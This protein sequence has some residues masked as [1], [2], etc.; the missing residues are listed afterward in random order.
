MVRN[1]SK[2][3]KV[4]PAVK[5]KLSE[6]KRDVY[7][8]ARVTNTKQL[9]TNHK[10]FA[11]LDFRRRDSWQSALQSLNEFEEWRSNPPEQYKEI[12]AEI[13]QASKDHDAHVASTKK[14][15]QDLGASVEELSQLTEDAQ[16]EAKELK[17]ETLVSI[18]IS[19]PEKSR[20]QID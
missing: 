5:Q 19:I 9:K 1:Q 15:F 20:K 14:I 6:L 12:F 2:S 10:E 16:K 8:L 7:K 4:V 13:D 11:S 18:P 17:E 3:P